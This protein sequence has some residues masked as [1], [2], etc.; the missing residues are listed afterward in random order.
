MPSRIAIVLHVIVV[1]SLAV[2]ALPPKTEPTAAADT[3][4]NMPSMEPVKAPPKVALGSFSAALFAPVA[5]P[6]PTTPV[7]IALVSML[8]E[9]P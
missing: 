9:A 7:K 1:T 5:I 3:P 4:M 6:T 2:M 8:L